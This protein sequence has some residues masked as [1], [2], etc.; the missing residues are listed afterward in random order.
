MNRNRLILTGLVA[1]ALIAALLLTGVFGGTGDAVPEHEQA[2]YESDRMTA[3]G[4][5][6]GLAGRRSGASRTAPPAAGPRGPLTVTVMNFGGHPL[7]GIPVVVA[8]HEDITGRS[9]NSQTARSKRADAK[10][11]VTFAS[12]PYDGSYAVGL[13]MSRVQRKAW[14]DAGVEDPSGLSLLALDARLRTS[15]VAVDVNVI[16]GPDEI[17][18][19]SQHAMRYR[20]EAFDV[21]RGRRVPDVKYHPTTYFVDHTGRECDAFI[22]GGRI[23]SGALQIRRTPPKSGYLVPYPFVGYGTLSPLAHT[24]HLVDTLQPEAAITVSLD[25]ASKTLTGKRKKGYAIVGHEHHELLLD[26]TDGFGRTR[27]IGIPFVPHAEVD[28]TV[29]LGGR[30][31]GHGV[32]RLGADPDVPLHIELKVLP[33]EEDGLPFMEDFE[34]IFEEDI[35]VDMDIAPHVPKSTGAVEIRVLRPNG[36]PA[37]GATVRGG[38]YTAHLDETGVLSLSSVVPG[39]HVFTIEGAGA[40]FTHRLEVA[41]GKTAKATVRGRLGGQILV[42]ATAKGGRPL[43]GAMAIIALGERTYLNVKDGVQTLH[44]TVDHKG[45]LLMHLVPGGEHTLH[46]RYL[47]ATVSVRAR[48]EPGKTTLAAVE[49]AIK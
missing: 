3:E 26:A 39:S 6:G 36:K 38:G 18:I 43:V 4:T 46:V 49:F 25:D 5:R 34:E 27:V 29:G 33:A 48:V 42:R 10:G 1:C 37:T 30:L 23:S 11:R 16:Q 35:E 13:V 7:A 44:R 12:V 22:V 20:V 28:I 41:G 47:G 2:G 40:P 45:E 8:P 14:K 31:F 19:L 32:G 17:R 9:F 24:V 15:V 21:V